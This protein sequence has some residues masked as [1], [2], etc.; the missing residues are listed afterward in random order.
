MRDD[1][2]VK[3]CPKCRGTEVGFGLEKKPQNDG[4][5]VSCYKCRIGQLQPFKTTTEA[6][7][8]WNSRPPDCPS[9]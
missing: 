8:D 5:R 4:W 6:I 7:A 1:L 3:P 9:Q 2:I